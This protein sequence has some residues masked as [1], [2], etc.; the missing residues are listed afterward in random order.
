MYSFYY[1]WMIISLLIVQGQ[2]APIKKKNSGF[3]YWSDDPLRLHPFDVEVII[4]KFFKH[5]ISSV[6]LILENKI[7][8]V[9]FLPL[10]IYFTF[11]WSS[12][13]VTELPVSVG[14]KWQLVVHIRWLILFQ[15]FVFLNL[16]KEIFTIYGAQRNLL[17][18]E[19]INVGSSLED[20]VRIGD[21][22]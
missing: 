21:W 1:E 17:V 20:A 7:R 11:L 22:N 5:L 6:K 10:S 15:F 12:N 3:F 4:I 2:L 16:F 14:R 18:N 9:I 8:Q 13:Y 19:L